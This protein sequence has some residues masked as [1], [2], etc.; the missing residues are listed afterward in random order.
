ML[1]SALL[2]LCAA[3]ADDPALRE[4]MVKFDR[5]YVAALVLTNREEAD[6]SKAAMAALQERWNAFRDAWAGARP[7]DPQWKADFDRAGAA[8]DAA[9]A[10]ADA[11]DLRK[12]HEQLESVRT[13]FRDLRRRH[14]IFYALD[15][16]TDFHAAMESL[17]KAVQGKTAETL[18]DED[19]AALRKRNEEA[20]TYWVVVR[21]EPADEDLFGFDAQKRAARRESIAEET[22]ALGELEKALDAANKAAIL[23]RAS[24]LKPPF[25]RLFMLYGDLPAAAK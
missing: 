18:T 3:P 10:A 25:A 21:D 9:R 4:A 16:L 24:A 11:G 2:I 22:L 17:V 15:P 23:E 7:E 14:E 8:I 5:A 13:I 12:A 19:V 20:R 6:P 1:L